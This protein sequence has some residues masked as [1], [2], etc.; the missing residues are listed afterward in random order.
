[1]GKTSL[2]ALAV[3][4]SLGLMAQKKKGNDP[5]IPLFGVVEKA[6]LKMK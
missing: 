6:N 3:R 4:L 1:M 5:N 2:L